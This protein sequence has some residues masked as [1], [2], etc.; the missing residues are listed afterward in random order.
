MK[1]LYKMLIAVMYLEYVKCSCDARCSG[2]NCTSGITD[3]R[4][5]YAHCMAD[6]CSVACFG[7][8]CTSVCTGLMCKAGCEGDQCVSNC[9]GHQCEK[10]VMLW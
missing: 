4:Q 7:D 10:H 5:C 9:S 3:T 6:S 1:P 8:N 2:N